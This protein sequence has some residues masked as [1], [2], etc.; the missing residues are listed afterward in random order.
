MRK[1]KG[2]ALVLRLRTMYVEIGECQ[3]RAKTAK[4]GLLSLLYLAEWFSQLFLGT[5]QTYHHTCKSSTP[6]QGVAV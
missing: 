2:Y 4:S 3:K 5:I 6:L 1:E